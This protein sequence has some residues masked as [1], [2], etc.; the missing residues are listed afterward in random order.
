MATDLYTVLPGLEVSQDEILQAELAAQKILEA[1]YPDLDLRQGTGLRDLVIRPSATLLAL[2]NKAVLYYFDQN[3]LPGITDSSPTEIVDKILSNWFVERKAGVKSV[4]SARMYFA[5]TK[6]VTIGTEVFFSPDNIKKFYPVST[7]SFS[8]SDLQYETFSGEYYVDIDLVADKEGS[9]YDLT[10]GSLLYFSNFDAYFLRGEINY[11]KE[12]STVTE[13]NS[14]FISR[15][16]TAVSTRNLINVP[17]IEARLREDFNYITSVTSIGY[18]DPEMYRDQVQVMA[19]PAVNPILIHIGGKTDVYTR[20]P[21]QTQVLQYVTDA[22]GVASIPGPF[23]EVKRSTFSGGAANDTVAVYRTVPITGITY[24]GTLATVT[25][26]AHGFTAG[27]SVIISGASL[28]VFNGTFPVVTV[29]DANSFTYAM[30]SV[31]ASGAI[32]SL[33]AQVPTAYNVTYPNLKVVSATLANVSGTVTVTSH[34]HGIIPGRYV[35][36]TGALPITF[37]GWFLVNTV[38]KDTFTISNATVGLPSSATGTPLVHLTDPMQDTGFSDNQVINV[39]FGITNANRTVSFTS[40]G[41]QGLSGIQTYFEDSSRKVLAGDLLARG[42]NIYYLTLSIIGYNG[43]PPNAV[44]CSTTT[45]AYLAS[46]VPGAPFIMADL[47]A[48][49]N[50]AGVTTIRTPIN[51]SYRYFHRDNIPPVPGVITDFLDPADRTAI[52]MLENLT[53]NNEYL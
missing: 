50:A 13:S 44:D 6:N 36:I 39:D 14:A 7:Y 49:L 20:V 12:I 41:F 16:Q 45:S 42:Y 18:G 43:P 28:P 46:L 31:P 8:P 33:I 5:V 38:T 17:S 25:A 29:L 19:P 11:L 30:A 26:P 37:N 15:T 32:G 22:N 21:L 52:F 10:S 3:T 9:D 35:Q 4:I 48:K 51:V 40:L 2:V 47:I 23:L 27:Q 24:V 34:D 1:Q 53:T